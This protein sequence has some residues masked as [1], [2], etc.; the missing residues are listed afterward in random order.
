MTLP[1][2]SIIT[3]V[4]NVPVRFIRQCYESIVASTYSQ[5]VW[6]IVDDGSADDELLD[7]YRSLKDSRIRQYSS[8]H[9][10]V[11]HARNI[12]LQALDSDYFLFLD[13]DDVLSPFCLENSVQLAQQH[14]ADIVMGRMEDFSAQFTYEEQENPLVTVFS[15]E[16]ELSILREYALSYIPPKDLPFDGY[17]WSPSHICSKLVKTSLLDHVRFN[18]KMTICEDTLFFIELFE[19]A[20]R[21]VISDETW[22]GYRKHPSST[23][24]QTTLSVLGSQLDSFTIFFDVAVHKQWDMKALGVRF[25]AFLADRIIYHPHELSWKEIRSFLIMAD[26][27]ETFCASQQCD[28]SLWDLSWKRRIS[29]FLIQKKCNL[30]AAL[31][32]KAGTHTR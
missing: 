10:G 5:W 15:K 28:L 29:Y 30:L 11:S 16:S 6:I 9:R 23:M 21:I 22:Y 32:L 8:P 4:Y 20:Q 18:E 26:N 19:K 3:P 24:S 17:R 13:A 31:L 27:N 12:A 2:I 14:D 7:F 25:V 1:T